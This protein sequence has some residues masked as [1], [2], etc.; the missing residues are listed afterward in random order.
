VSGHSRVSLAMSWCLV[1]E[2]FYKDEKMHVKRKNR[3]RIPLAVRCSMRWG[4]LRHWFLGAV[5]LEV[6]FA[7]FLWSHGRIGSLSF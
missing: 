7:H 2:K 6:K 3:D 4:K 1:D 5:L